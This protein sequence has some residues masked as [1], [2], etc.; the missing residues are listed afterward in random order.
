VCERQKEDYFER[1]GGQAKA[2]RGW[3]EGGKDFR[4]ESER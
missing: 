2:E 4:G 3:R 1:M